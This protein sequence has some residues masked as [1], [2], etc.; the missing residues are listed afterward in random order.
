MPK[1]DMTKRVLKTIENPNVDILLH[2]TTRQIQKREPIQL[3]MER[4]ISAARDNGTILD[5][6]SYPDR[7]DLKDEHIRKAVEIGAK[8]GISSDAHATVHMHYLELGIA[9]AR[10]GWATAKNVVNTRKLQEFQKMLKS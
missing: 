9:Q 4:I 7:L 5:I 10:R 8:L 3:D 6:D 1:Q 2:P